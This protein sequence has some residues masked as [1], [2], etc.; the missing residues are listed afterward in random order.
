MVQHG[1]T[2]PMMQVQSQLKAVKF[3]IQN[4]SNM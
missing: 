3:E 2:T 4:S 1:A